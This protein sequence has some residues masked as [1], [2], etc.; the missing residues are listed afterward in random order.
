MV[1]VVNPRNKQVLV[2]TSP[3]DVKVL[4]LGDTL[5]G[6]EVV[7]GWTLSVEELFGD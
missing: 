6:G 3:T 7:P 4:G 2:H 1:A 5:E